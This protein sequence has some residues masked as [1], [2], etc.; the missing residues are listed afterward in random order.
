[1]RM[2]LPR[3]ASYPLAMHDCRY[4]TSLAVC[5]SSMTFSTTVPSLKC[6]FEATTQIFTFEELGNTE[7]VYAQNTS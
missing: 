3:P 1:M 7:G 6:A 2:S 5:G 4:V